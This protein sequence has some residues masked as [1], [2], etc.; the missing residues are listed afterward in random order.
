MK[1]AMLCPWNQFK[2]V[3][4]M[5]DAEISYSKEAKII[6][7]CATGIFFNCDILLQFIAL[8]ADERLYS[9]QIESA[10]SAMFFDKLSND[11]RPI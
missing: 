4:D 6:K 5:Q 11:Q 3:N 1:V 2:L 8:K 7:I 10:V 9:I